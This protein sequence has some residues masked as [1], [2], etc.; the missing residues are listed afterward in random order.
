M[1]VGVGVGV[2]ETRVCG[3]WGVVGTAVTAISSVHY[4]VMVCGK[5]IS[6]TSA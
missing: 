1:S 4:C 6:P 2:G 3:V 5:A